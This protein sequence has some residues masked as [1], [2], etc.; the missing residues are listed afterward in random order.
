MSPVPEFIYRSFSAWKQAKYARFWKRSFSPRDKRG[1]ETWV[2]FGSF[3][4]CFRPHQTNMLVLEEK[5]KTTLP[6]C[7]QW[8]Q[9]T[10]TDTI[11]RFFPWYLQISKS[12]CFLVPNAGFHTCKQTLNAHLLVPIKLGDGSQRMFMN[13]WMMFECIYCIKKNKC[14]KSGIRPP[15]L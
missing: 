15:N 9:A 10:S 6:E 5:M 13:E 4:A 1:S 8:K 12:F 2:V 11:Y 14:K 7:F 3:L